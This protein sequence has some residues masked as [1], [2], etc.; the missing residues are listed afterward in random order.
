MGL[1]EKS[2]RFRTEVRQARDQKTATRAWDS[3]HKGDQQI[4]V[5]V[6]LRC[7]ALIVLNKLDVSGELLGRYK[8]IEKNL[9]V[10]RDIV[11]K[12]QVGQWSSELPWF[13]R[14]N[15]KWSEKRGEFLEECKWLKLGSI[16]LGS[17]FGF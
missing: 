5:A 1:A 17:L 15:G 14:V 6:Q 3:I 13:W 12:N 10:S 7:L 8:E 4:K 9:K 16:H 11:E 2:L